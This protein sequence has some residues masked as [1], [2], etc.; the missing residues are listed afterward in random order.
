MATA[1]WCSDCNANV[2]VAAD[3]GCSN[4]HPRS[5]LRGLYQVPPAVGSAPPAVSTPAPQAHLPAH[6]T[7]GQIGVTG[8]SGQDAVEVAGTAFAAHEL[9]DAATT[10]RQKRRSAVRSSIGWIQAIA[11]FTV[12]NAVAA[13]LDFNVRMVVGASIADFLMAIGKHF[14]SVA[15]GAALVAVLAIAGAY[16]ALAWVFKKRGLIWAPVVVIVFY[17]LDLIFTLLFRDF[18]GVAFHGLAIFY[19]VNGTRAFRALVLE[20][21]TAQMTSAASAAGIEEAPVPQVL[22]GAT[23]TV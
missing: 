20:R 16:Y 3:G 9:A 18:F 11:A 23:E 8:L 4:G 19:M 17:S 7:S 13:L 10:L 21:R 14:G 1:G 2:W 5:S 22:S 15:T 6:G 12:L